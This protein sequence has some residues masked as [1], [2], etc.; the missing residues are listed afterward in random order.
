MFS[1][2]PFLHEDARR[3]QSR[4]PP[5]SPLSLGAV[6]SA[7]DPHPQ[8]LETKALGLVDEMDDPGPGHL[9]DHPT[10]ISAVT[11][12]SG[13]F[14]PAD[15]SSVATSGPA[16]TTTAPAT[17]PLPAASNP[18][19]PLFG[20]LDQRFV[21]AGLTGPASDTMIIDEDKENTRSQS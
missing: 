10:P 12:L 4:S 18:L 17:G 21:R 3:S 15:G 19:R 9:S 14:N 2:I 7:S 6:A 11:T 8:A 13:H 20:S 16:G 1:P 5:P